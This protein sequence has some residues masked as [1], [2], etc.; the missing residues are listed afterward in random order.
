MPLTPDCSEQLRTA[1]ES[2]PQYGM[3]LEPDLKSAGFPKKSQRSELSALPL[4]LLEASN[5]IHGCAA[6]IQSSE[7]LASEAN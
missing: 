4:K 3:E 6:G 5:A 7:I 1:W 2:N